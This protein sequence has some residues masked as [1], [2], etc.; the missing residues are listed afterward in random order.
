MGTEI[1]F[2]LGKN[3]GQMPSSLGCRSIV[4]VERDTKYL[5]FT[6]FLKFDNFNSKARLGCLNGFMALTA[7]Y[8]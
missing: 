4:V 3:G 2:I 1:N 7:L 5:Q 6:K 8:Q